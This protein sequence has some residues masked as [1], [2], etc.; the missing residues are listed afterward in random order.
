MLKVPLLVKVL[1]RLLAVAPEIF[2]V[3]PEFIVIG[4]PMVPPTRF[5]IPF[6]ENNS[7]PAV[8]PAA[9]LI[10]NP[11][12]EVTGVFTFNIP[13][14]PR[15]PLPDRT[16]PLF[17]SIIPKLVSVPVFTAML[18]LLVN[19]MAIPVIP[20]PADLVKLPVLFNAF[21]PPKLFKVPSKELSML[22]LF[23]SVPLLKLIPPAVQFTVPLLVKT[24]D[25]V[26]DEPLAVRTA[27]AVIM[28]GDPI[29]PPVQFMVPFTVHIPVPA[30][31]LP[32]G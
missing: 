21:V 5:M 25:N 19:G 26:L 9:F 1:L 3:A 27:G 29:V 15:V 28:K 24:A 10:I 31:R 22:P 17:R 4:E 8:L 16:V 2:M 23:V 30:V 6:T 32:P 11:E 13:S 14:V 7:E 20:V 12:G 18:P